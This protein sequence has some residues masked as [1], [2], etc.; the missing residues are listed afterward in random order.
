MDLLLPLL[1]G[2]GIAFIGSVPIAGPLAAL[3]VRRATHGD[4]RNGLF[5]AFGGAIAEGLIALLVGLLFP[6]FG[7]FVD[8]VVSIARGLGAVVL[9]GAGI[10]LFARPNTGE[11][12]VPKR[13][14]VSFLVGAAAAGLNPTIVATWLLVITTLYGMNLLVARVATAPLFAL[15]VV[16]G[17]V[18]WFAILLVVGE[19]LMHV[20]TDSRRILLMR[21]LGLAMIV[22]SLY[23]AVRLFEGD[24]EDANQRRSSFCAIC[25]PSSVARRVALS[26]AS[27][28]VRRS[29]PLSSVCR[30]AIAVPPGLVTMSLSRPGCSP[31]SSS[32]LAEPYTV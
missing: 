24:R 3:I 18:A 7:S 11:S 8:N 32:S 13:R 23:L 28:K 5:I 2:F 22:A 25:S 17:V 14:R 29:P 27:I 20:I 4:Y 12:V 21:V 10:L 30:P 26:T 1:L 16:A 15:G 6:L 31:V 19:R 9:L